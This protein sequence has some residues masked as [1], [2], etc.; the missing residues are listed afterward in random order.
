MRE[1]REKIL[2]IREAIEQVEKHAVEGKDAFDR[3]ELIQIWMI[4]HIQIIGEAARALSMDFRKNH[5]DWPWS[6]MIGM[7]NILVHR[8]FGVDRQAVWGVVQ[9]DLPL[10]KTSVETV[11]HE[12]Q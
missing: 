6:Q 11:L 7:R 8:Y 5:P 1:D 4:H 3:D 10:L 12:L 2:D 9:H